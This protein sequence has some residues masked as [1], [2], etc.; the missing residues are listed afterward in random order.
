MSHHDVL[1]VSF[2]QAHGVIVTKPLCD[3]LT[4]V[5]FMARAQTDAAKRERYEK[6]ALRTVEDAASAPGGV[7]AV[8]WAK[9]GTIMPPDATDDAP[10]WWPASDSATAVA[11]VAASS[12]PSSA[13]RATLLEETLRRAPAE[14]QPFVHHGFDLYDREVARGQRTYEQVTFVEMLNI[15]KTLFAKVVP[16]S[17]QQLRQLAQRPQPQEQQLPPTHPPAEAPRLASSISNI[18]SSSS[19]PPPP[20]Y[21]TL[22]RSAAFSSCEP[23]AKRTCAAAAAVT[24]PSGLS[25]STD[26]SFFMQLAGTFEV[27]KASP[28]AFVG[29]S[30]AME[31]AYTRYE[32]LV[33]D[34][35][36]LPVLRSAFLYI[37][38]R[39]K[40]MEAAEGVKAGQ[41]YLSDQLKGMRQ[42]LRV[43]NIVTGFTVKVYEQHAQ[44][45]LEM[46]DIGEFNQCQAALKHLY[47]SPALNLE[48][49]HARDFFLYR[50]VYLTLSEQYDSLSTELIT[51]TNA[52][53]TGATPHGM[54]VD[55]N[56]MNRT[57]A[58]CNACVNGDTSTIC[59]LLRDFPVYMSYL[60][61][62]YLQKLRITWLREILVAMK[63]SLTMRFL[64]ASL[65]FTAVAESDAARS[66]AF[67]LDG[68]AEEA[69]THLT[70][71]FKTLKID[72][73]ANFSFRAEGQRTKHTGP[74]PNARFP[75]LD[76]ASALK[77][78]DDYLQYLSTRKD[79]ILG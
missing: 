63:G 14:L 8:K 47:E 41:K 60:V 56:T 36:P 62:I 76:A 22:K 42:D 51:F 9:Q 7:T 64:M 77:A 39:A 24:A 33:D 46:G 66:H 20:Q 30:T 70:D 69:E 15:A 16:R 79:A 12:P 37:V 4:R 53:L 54:D 72:L 13:T 58:L 29:R 78:V 34:I 45:C 10:A 48:R 67:W 23:P 2:L 21:S 40:A 18:A 11:A 17:Q 26:R 19:S 32:P 73:P 44:L 74:N 5:S 3:W 55:K 57:L 38:R 59:R 6:W 27:E 25:P 61:R 31:R 71:L 1:T 50:V 65:G 35:R 75:S 68:S 52:Q 49:C 43:Q 28:P